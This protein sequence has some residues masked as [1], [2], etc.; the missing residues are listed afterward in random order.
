[1][2][3]FRNKEQRVPVKID[4]DTAFSLPRLFDIQIIK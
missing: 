3:V 4:A 2:L 1:M